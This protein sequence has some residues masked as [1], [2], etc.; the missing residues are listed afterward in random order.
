M[1]LQILYVSEAAGTCQQRKQALEDLGH[2]VHFVAS[3]E[4]PPRSGDRSIGW[5]ITSHSRPIC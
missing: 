2:Q 5:V 4:P 1:G 3:G